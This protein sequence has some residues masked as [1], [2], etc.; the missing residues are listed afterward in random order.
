MVWSVCTRVWFYFCTGDKKNTQ[1]NG[2]ERREMHLAHNSSLLKERFSS[3]ENS[4]HTQVGRPFSR[5]WNDERHERENR[6]CGWRVLHTRD[7]GS[8]AAWAFLW[9]WGPSFGVLFAGRWPPRSP[10]SDA[11]CCTLLSWIQYWFT[12]SKWTKYFQQHLKVGKHT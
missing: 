2:W 9:A 10:A 4:I 3:Y 5:L 1:R 6:T 7:V 8:F 12:K 11:I